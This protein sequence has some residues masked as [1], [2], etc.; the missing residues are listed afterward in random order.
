[1]SRAN[2]ILQAAL[3]MDCDDRAALAEQLRA[4]LVD[5]SEVENE[6]LRLARRSSELTDPALAELWN[7]PRDAAYDD[8]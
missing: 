3:R 6:G 1:M 4:S 7:N 8:L 5:L 2:E